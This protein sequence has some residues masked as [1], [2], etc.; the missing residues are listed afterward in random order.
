MIK[1]TRYHDALTSILPPGCG[2][3]TTLLTVANYRVLAGLSAEQIFQD[4]R[5]AHQQDRPGRISP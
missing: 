1:Q 3:H 2:C 4:I 5:Q